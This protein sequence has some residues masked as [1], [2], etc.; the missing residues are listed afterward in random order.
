MIIVYNIPKFWVYY[1]LDAPKDRDNIRGCFAVYPEGSSLCGSESKQL[2]VLTRLPRYGALRTKTQNN[3]LRGGETY[4]CKQNRLLH[5]FLHWSI[6]LIN[7]FQC[8][9]LILCIIFRTLPFRMNV[10]ICIDLR[11]W[12]IYTRIYGISQGCCKSSWA[13]ARSFGS[14]RKHL[15]MRSVAPAMSPG[16]NIHPESRI[17]CW[18][19]LRPKLLNFFGRPDHMWSK[20]LTKRKI[21]LNRTET[22]S[23]AENNLCYESNAE[24]NL[25]WR[26]RHKDWS[27]DKAIRRLPTHHVP[28]MSLV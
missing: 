11:G 7:I 1:Y 26:I 14:R 20:L 17:H 4:G 21:K 19:G 8:N 28:W 15:V 6:T 25:V 13:V 27:F 16:F 23:P 3:R 18:N 24:E 2:G 5:F 10:R 9:G 22:H 12:K